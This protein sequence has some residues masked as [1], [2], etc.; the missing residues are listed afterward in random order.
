LEKEK[1]K[2]LCSLHVRNCLIARPSDSLKSEKFEAA[3]RG[4]L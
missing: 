1:I 2:A 4:D 3:H